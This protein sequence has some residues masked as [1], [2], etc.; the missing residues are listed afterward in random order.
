MY[1]VGD[2]TWEFGWKDNSLYYKPSD[3]P[4]L[5]IGTQK[6]MIMKQFPNTGRF[7]GCFCPL[8]ENFLEEGDLCQ[9]TKHKRFAS[10][11]RVTISVKGIHRAD[12]RDKEGG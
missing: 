1:P 8:L 10:I 3:Y 4:P 7:Y 12:S 6:E 2:Y 9:I 5:G 11:L